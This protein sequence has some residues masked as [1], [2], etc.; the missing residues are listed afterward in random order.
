MY[1]LMPTIVGE[2]FLKLAE[3]LDQQEQAMNDYYL[4]QQAF[5]VVIRPF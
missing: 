3:L 4:Q 1:K 5:K 2:I